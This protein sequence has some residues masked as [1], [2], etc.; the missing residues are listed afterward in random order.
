MIRDGQVCPVCF[1]G[2]LRRGD[3]SEVFTYHGKSFSY[4][5]PGDWCDKCDEGILNGEDL[6]STEEEVFDF[7]QGID[8]D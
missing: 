2:T 7:M 6:L 1:N 3:K 5:Q 4:T 8:N